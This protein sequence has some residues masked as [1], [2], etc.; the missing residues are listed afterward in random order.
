MKND[1][2]NTS[3]TEIDPEVSEAV[4]RDGEDLSLIHI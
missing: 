2:L 3:I 4:S 1:F